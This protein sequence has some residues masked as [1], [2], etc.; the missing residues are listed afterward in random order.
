LNVGSFSDYAVSRCCCDL[1]VVL[2][3]FSPLL[4]IASR[5]LSPLNTT[6]FFF[7]KKKK[8]ENRFAEQRFYPSIMSFHEGIF[9]VGK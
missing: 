1:C 9:Y 4:F 7:F 2:S 6:F 3:F 8:I 5:N